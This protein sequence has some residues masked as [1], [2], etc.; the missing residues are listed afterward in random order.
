MKHSHD[1]DLNFAGERQT[2]EWAMRLRV[3]VYIAEALEYCSNEGH[4]LYHDLN[5]YRVFFD[6][7]YFITITYK[8]CLFPPAFM[9]I[10]MSS[11]MSIYSLFMQ[12]L[13]F[14]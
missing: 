2:I 6:E 14:K 9:V 13:F 3:A 10:Q 5:A 11:C 7:V 4:Q 1:I 12:L 8:F